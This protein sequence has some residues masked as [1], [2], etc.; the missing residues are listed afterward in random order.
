MT[1]NI[2]QVNDDVTVPVL[3]IHHTTAESTTKPK[4]PR[5]SQPK[6]INIELFEIYKCIYGDLLV[7]KRFVIPSD[8]RW[9]AI[10]HG[11]RFGTDVQRI[12][13]SFTKGENSYDQNDIDTLIE[14]GFVLNAMVDNS[15]RTLQ[16]FQE[17]KLK[18]GNCNIPSR[19]RIPMNDVSWPENVRG[20]RLGSI[21]DTIKRKSIYQNIYAQLVELGVDFSNKYVVL[22]FA[23]LREALLTYK[24]IHGHLDLPT[25]YCI[26]ADDERY[27]PKAWGYNLGE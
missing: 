17:Y 12:R 22:P 26:P 5:L 14:N 1:E 9:P 4:I 10:H 21:V 8:D 19:Y 18:F 16:A 15:D 11:R 13:Q 20:V 2:L 25:K 23:D 24:S 3:E 7:P 6:R 27:S